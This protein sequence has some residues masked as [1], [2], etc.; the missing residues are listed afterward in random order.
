MW[1]VCATSLYNIF[2]GQVPYST[3]S[4]SVT[5]DQQDLYFKRT[6]SLDVRAV[7]A[8]AICYFLCAYLS[9]TCSMCRREILETSKSS[10]FDAKSC[11]YHY[12]TP[13]ASAA[14]ELMRA[15]AADYNDAEDISKYIE[16]NTNDPQRSC[17]HDTTSVLCTSPCILLV[18]GDKGWDHC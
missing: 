18:Q 7:V 6:R 15:A 9:I 10:F 11:H 16:E 17:H 2:L 5:R 3:G 1:K 12:I 8:A 14:A 13:S 4:L